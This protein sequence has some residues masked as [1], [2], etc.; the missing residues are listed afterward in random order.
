MT[1][2]REDWDKFLKENEA[3][4]RD[5]DGNGDISYNPDFDSIADFFIS[6]MRGMIEDAFDKSE[7]KCDSP[8]FEE[9]SVCKLKYD[10]LTEIGE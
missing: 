5:E 3:G 10:L 4:W 2:L 7:V 1:T 9:C 6:R 8:V